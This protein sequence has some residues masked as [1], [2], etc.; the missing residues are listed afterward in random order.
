[1]GP[2]MQGG[3]SKVTAGRPAVGQLIQ[4]RMGERFTPYSEAAKTYPFL[5]NHD[6]AYMATPRANEGFAETWPAGET[7]TPDR[8]RPNQFPIERPGIQ[9]FKP[10]QFS[11]NDIAGEALHID[12][13]V[14]R[15]QQKLAPT[16][17]QD[18]WAELR[19][20]PDYEMGD[21]DTK[22]RENSAIAAAVRGYAVKQWPQEAIDRFWKPDQRAVLDGL[23]RY[24]ST[25]KE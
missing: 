21:G 9:V 23:T 11:S 5:R 4:Q 14:A 7:G 13:V 1:M 2:D 16:L 24:M 17:S 19:Q 20:Q 3:G 22:Q 10:K 15:V 25:G 6:M 12:P 8:P 18:Q